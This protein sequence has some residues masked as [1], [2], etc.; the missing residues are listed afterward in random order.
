MNIIL[1]ISVKNTHKFYKL[2]QKLY[3]IIIFFCAFNTQRNCLWLVMAIAVEHSGLHNRVALRIIMM[4]R[5]ID[6]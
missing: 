3:Y 4:V 2:L 6:N 1:Y 5:N